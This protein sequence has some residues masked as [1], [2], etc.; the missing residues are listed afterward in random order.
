MISLTCTTCKEVLSIDDAFAGGVCR[1]RNCG[2]IQ[3]V[4]AKSKASAGGAAVASKTLYRKKSSS[5]GG[6]STG[7]GL[8]DLADVVA[9]SG[10]SGSGLANRRHS[11]KP[12]AAPR[13]SVATTLLAISGVVV[14]VLAGLLLWVVLGSGSGAKNPV[15]AAPGAELGTGS[16]A[17]EAVPLVTGPSFCGVKLESPSVIYV[18]DRGQ[19]MTES[20]DALKAA[21]AKSLR[22]LGPDKKFQ[23]IFWTS[24]ARALAIPEEGPSPATPERV[25]ACVRAL[26]EVTPFGRTSSRSAIEAAAAHMPGEI[27]LATGKGSSLEED[28]LAAVTDSIKGGATKVHTFSLGAAESPVLKKIAEQTGGQH[29]TLTPEQLRRFGE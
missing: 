8:D 26:E 17:A 9:S 4:P 21:T 10:L 15:P 16:N 24:D 29:R 2:T 6:A 22:S 14:M 13:K 18:L 23:I 3:T 5:S 1:C 12:S 7:T 25:D 11:A 28:T 19:A 20:L 27:I